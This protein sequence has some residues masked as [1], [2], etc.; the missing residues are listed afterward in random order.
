VLW[1]SGQQRE[2][3]KVW[4]KALKDQPDSPVLRSTLLRLTGSEQP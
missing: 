1:V 3:R 2:A 4:S